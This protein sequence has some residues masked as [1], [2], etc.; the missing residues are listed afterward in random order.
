[1]RP[2][3]ACQARG[4]LLERQIATLQREKEALLRASEDRAGSATASEPHLRG[5]APQPQLAA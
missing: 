3:R 5:F 1:M 2:R 4:E